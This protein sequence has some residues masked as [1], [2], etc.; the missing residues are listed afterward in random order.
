MKYRCIVID[1]EALAIDILEDFIEK[2]PNLELIGK[3]S[4]PLKATPLLM[5]Q[6]VDLIFLDINMPDISGT[7]FYENLPVKPLVIFTTAYSDFAVKGFEMNAVDYLLKPISFERFFK[8]I[9]KLGNKSNSLTIGN[10]AATLPVTSEGNDYIFVKAEYSSIKIK[11]SDIVMLEGYKDYVK[12]HL[13]NE[14]K[15]ILT[16]NSVKHYETTLFSKG[17]V[18]I[19]KR[20][21]VSIDKIE[22]ISRNRVKVKSKDEFILIGESFRDFFMELVVNH[23]L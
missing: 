3:F 6:E 17:F 19:H 11:L 16:L 15:P 1:D 18:R 23:H 22:N 13:L 20:Y 8:A 9:N 2:F 7:A 5:S 12:I 4:S 21:I 14:P 10:P